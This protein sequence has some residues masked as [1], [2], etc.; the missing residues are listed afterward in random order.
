MTYMATL[1]TI[2]DKKETESCITNRFS[3]SFWYQV[4]PKYNVSPSLLLSLREYWPTLYLYLDE[5]VEQMGN[6]ANIW[7]YSLVPSIED[8]EFWIYLQNILGWKQVNKS[9]KYYIAGR[10]TWGHFTDINNSF[11][12]INV[13]ALTFPLTAI[14]TKRILT[15][16]LSIHWR[17]WGTS[18]KLN[19]HLGIFSG[20]LHRRL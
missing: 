15:N 5:C 9:E 4:F 14:E 20:I 7:G 17:V 6:Q 1:T 2:P 10:Q 11:Q 12:N 3:F 8:N 13:I 19:Q 16:P 18:G